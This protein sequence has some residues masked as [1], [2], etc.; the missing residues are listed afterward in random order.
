VLGVQVLTP[1]WGRVLIQ[2]H[3]GALVNVEGRVPTPHGNISVAWKRGKTFLMTLVLPVGVT[4]KVEL[5]AFQGSRGVW[6]GGK[7]VQARREGQWW[8]LKNE[9]SGTIYVEER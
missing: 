3:P 7:H 4:A 8:K 9:A 5:P 2:P 6:I 1:A